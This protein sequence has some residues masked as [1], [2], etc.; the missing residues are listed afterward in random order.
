V[1]SASMMLDHLGEVDAAAALLA[2]VRRVLGNTD[3]R[4]PDL[5]GSSTTDDVASAIAAELRVESG[6]S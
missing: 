3:T 4:T 2:A 5:G 1:W 6:Q